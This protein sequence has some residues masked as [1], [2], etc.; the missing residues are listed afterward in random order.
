LGRSSTA[1]FYRAGYFGA[2]LG[3]STTNWR[4]RWSKLTLNAAKKSLR[5]RR[6][7]GVCERLTTASAERSIAETLSRHSPRLRRSKVVGL[8]E[9]LELTLLLADRDPAKYEQAALRW[10]AR[11]MREVPK[12]EMRES[13]A[14]FLLSSR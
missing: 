12:V 2:E 13:Q 11:F 5:P 8:I 7:K 4:R 6:M 1:K 3:V 9:A 10:H 14:N